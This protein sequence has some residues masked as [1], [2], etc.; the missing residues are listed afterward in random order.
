MR[1]AGAA[2]L[3]VLAG[4]TTA[5]APSAQA[6][7]SALEVDAATL[8][9]VAA[10]DGL[11]ASEVAA[12]AAAPA[13]APAAP[14]AGQGA[15]ATADAD[16]G[17]APP[18]ACSVPG[19]GAGTCLPTSQCQ[20]TATPG[21]CPGAKDIQ[22]CTTSAATTCDPAAAPSPNDGLGSE[23]A[24]VGG[25]PAGMA[26]VEGA[27]ATAFCIDRWEA[28]LQ[29]STTGAEFSP[30]HNPGS[31]AVRAVSRPGQVPQGYI[32]GVQA[33]T[34]CQAAG[35]RLCSDNEWLRACQGT[36]KWTY[37]YG[38]KDQPKVCNDS[39]AVHPAIELYGTSAAWIWSKLDNACLDQLPDSLAKSGTYSGC[40]TPE[41]IHDL[42]GNLHEWTADPAGTFRGGYFVDTILNG[43]GCLYV[44]TAHD[45]AHWDY[46][47]GFRCCADAP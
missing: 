41:G 24:G 45:S 22:C 13:D 21:F 16:S 19:K 6:I 2:L 4:C 12:D 25:C 28:A 37:P 34:A 27:T 18:V 30:F 3:A 5:A 39:R 17:T 43:P 36:Q 35:K 1:L 26:R 33:K 38:P 47:T 7:D 23:P 31:T 44:T 40:I 42:M 20:G 29:V 9:D 10:L 32:S 46:S 14:D 15:D 8:A 11:A